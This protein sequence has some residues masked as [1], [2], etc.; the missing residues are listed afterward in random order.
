M[1]IAH[2]KLL[3]KALSSSLRKINVKT[4]LEGHLGIVKTKQLLKSKIW[5]PQIDRDIYF[6]KL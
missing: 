4:A 1:I 5:Y 6:V 2:N 3:E